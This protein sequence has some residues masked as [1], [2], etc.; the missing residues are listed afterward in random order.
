MRTAT[1][2][3]PEIL[4]H[5]ARLFA[6]KRF[7]EVLMDEVAA[8]AG[9]AKGTIY[10]FYPTKEKL[11]AAICF[12]WMDHLV[13]GMNRI[14]DGPG[15]V[16]ERIEKIIVFA[17]EHFRKHRDYFDVLQRQESQKVLYQLPQLRARRTAIR[18]IYARMVREG[19]KE[20]LFRSVSADSSADMLMG[21]VRSLL[22]FGDPERDSGAIAR[23]ALNLFLH[24]VSRNG[25]DKGAH[26]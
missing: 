25:H 21:M 12:D 8:K 26:A 2:H 17:T 3:R 7:D 10:R 1:D 19:Q 4:K 11:Y 24:G 15:S 22:L 6:K 18:K 14:A 20:G 9:I 13:A 23:D 16:V 5:A